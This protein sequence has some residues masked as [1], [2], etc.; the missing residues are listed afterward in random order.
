MAFFAGEQ[1]VTLWGLLAIVIEKYPEYLPIMGRRIIARA[2][3]DG[4]R[5]IRPPGDACRA[6]KRP[7]VVSQ[8]PELLKACT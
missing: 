8:V 5:P 3:I 1:L 2:Q 4:L 6:A 7:R